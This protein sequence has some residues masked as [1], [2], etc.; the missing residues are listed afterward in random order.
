M[1]V[2]TLLRRVHDELGTLGLASTAFLV[3]AALFFFFVLKPLEAR[4]QQLEQQ[5]ALIVRQNPSDSALVRTATPA[6]KMA[7]FYRFLKTGHATTDWLDRLYMAGQTAGVELRSADYQMQK[8]GA[9]MA[10]YEIRLPVSGNYAQIRSFLQNALAEI[11]VLSLD[12]VK[13][14][15]ERASDASVQA[16]LHLTLHLVNP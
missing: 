12:E 1:I 15:R 16:D 4:N 10:R 7:A 6:T 9:R 11:P 13:F 3:A 14:K 5:L 2:T 8:T